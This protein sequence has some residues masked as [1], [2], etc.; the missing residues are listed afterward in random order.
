[1]KQTKMGKLAGIIKLEGTLDGLTFYKSAD[2]YLVRTKGG[3]SKTKI[4]NDP[5]FARTRENL[6]EFGANAKSGKALRNS[7]GPL[8]NRAK[9]PKLSSRMLQMMN[10]IKN[11]DHSSARG[12]RSVSVGI[13]S[14]EG[15]Q[16][17][18]GFD[19]NVRA[20]L[21]TILRVPYVLEPE[22]GTVSISNF[23]AQEQLGFPES[24]THVSLRS[25]FVNLDF[26]TG[27]FDSSYSP[28]T[29]MA[30]NNSVSEVSLTPVLV[31]AGTGT[32]LYFLLIEFYQEVNGVQY[33]LRS[34]SFNVLNLIEVL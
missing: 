5:A 15:K 9:D 20:A 25:A 6:S 32:Q 3:V 22:T 11:F 24:A 10:D 30:I 7:I 23:V 8:L 4:M 27:I 31:P 1:M 19:F 12:Q 26:E 16:L 28:I 34:G 14:A 33:S 29:N 13:K 21:Q 18:K 17:L 2:G